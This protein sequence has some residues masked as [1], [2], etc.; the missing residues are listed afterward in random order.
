MTW[1]LRVPHLGGAEDLEG[2]EATLGT[3]NSTLRPKGM[4]PEVLRMP[5]LVL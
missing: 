5:I 1:E 3:W 2:L 4:D